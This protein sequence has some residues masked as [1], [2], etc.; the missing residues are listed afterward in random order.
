MKLRVVIV[1]DEPAALMLHRRFLEDYDACEVIAAAR[2]GPEAVATIRRHQPDLV[3]LDIYLPGFSGLDVLRTI[4]AGSHN[5]PEFIAVT[6]ARDF[7]SVRDARLLGVRHYLTKPFS[8]RDL[9]DRVDE[10]AREQAT[11]NSATLD[12]DSIDEFI[13]STGVTRTLPKG[14]SPD[15]L[16]AVRDALAE[17]PWSTA[18]EVGERI[19][20]SRVSSRRY[21]EFLTACGEAQRRQDYTTSGRP[22][23]R[24][25]PASS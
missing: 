22:S 5:Q 14:L 11:V 1:D 24:Y 10:V 23:S 13:G 16:Q 15:T 25:G 19:G 8:A 20:I 4:R 6:A 7:A 2:N 17:Q 3:L 21:L 18:K 9:R 12:Q